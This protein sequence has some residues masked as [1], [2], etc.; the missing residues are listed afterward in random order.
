MTDY[1]KIMKRCIKLAQKGAG[2][3]SPNP[4]VGCVVMNK[5]DKIISEGYHHKYGENHAEKDALLKLK[6][7]E[8]ADGTL[9]VNL[10]PCSHYGKTPPCADLIIEHKIK[11][12]IIGCRDTNPK[13]NGNGIAM[14]KNAGIEVICGVLHDECRKL[15][16]IFFTNIEEKRIYT[17]LKTAVTLD[18]KIAAAGGNSK[19]ITSDKSRNLA[20]SLRNKYDAVLTS[21]QTVILD[22]PKMCHKMK[23]VLDRTLKTNPNADIYKTGHVFIAID[24]NM[25]I[26]EDEWR[27][28]IEFIKCKIVNS[29]IDLRDLLSKLYQKGVF[30]IFVECGGKLSGSFV[31][32]NLVDK[33]YQ[34][35]APKILNDNSGR[36]CF[37]GDCSKLISDCKNFKVSSLKMSGEDIFIE[38]SK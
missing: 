27:S 35:I 14:L 7:G 8:D 13:V 11:R 9:V 12:V 21:S 15:N 19:W 25:E 29:Q 20:K 22:N 23:I 33:I 16:E 28:N 6:N 17:A 24:E 38:Y 10:E 32:Y 4:M 5:Y 1:A 34:F 26:N 36:S 3:T 30:S 18:G 31:K 2:K 37:D